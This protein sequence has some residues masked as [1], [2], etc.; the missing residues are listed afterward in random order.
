V[1]AVSFY[2]FVPVGTRKHLCSWC[3]CAIYPQ[4][5]MPIGRRKRLLQRYR[6]VGLVV[7]GLRTVLMC[8]CRTAHALR[9]RFYGTINIA[10]ARQTDI[11]IRSKKVAREGAAEQR[12]KNSLVRKSQE[13]RQIEDRSFFRCDPKLPSNIMESDVYVPNGTHL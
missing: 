1:V 4:I 2:K 5:L 11:N 10:S 6:P 8:V 9:P 7:P 12:P 3:L 13:Y